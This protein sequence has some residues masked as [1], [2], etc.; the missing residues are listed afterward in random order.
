MSAP[1]VTKFTNGQK[2]H[3]ADRTLWPER[4]VCGQGL[5]APVITLSP[6]LD[7]PSN[8][9]HTF[10][11]YRPDGTL[12]GINATGVYKFTDVHG[13]DPNGEEI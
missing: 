4:I 12:L 11:T 13:R 6:D 10:R 1:R 7:R 5:D 9:I 2:I 8:E 3:K